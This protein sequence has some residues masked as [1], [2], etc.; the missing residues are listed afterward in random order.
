V[1]YREIIYQKRQRM[2]TDQLLNWCRFMGLQQTLFFHQQLT[3]S[4]L[5]V[6]ALLTHTRGALAFW[7]TLPRC[8][9][10]GR[11]SK[12]EKRI[13]RSKANN[14]SAFLET[15]SG[16]SRHTLCV[17][18]CALTLG[19][20][21]MAQTIITFDVPGAQDT[22]AIAISNTGAITG[23][24]L[25]LDSA[26]HGFLRMPDGRFTSFD[27]PGSTLTFGYSINSR[28]EIT[29]Y[30]Y[31]AG[32]V[33]HGFVRAPGGRFTI[34][35]AP[36]FQGTAGYDINA[37]GEIAGQSV[38]SSGAVHSFVRAVDGTITVYDAPGAG[39]GPGQGTYV[40]TVDGL[41]PD[42]DSSGS[43]LDGSNVWHG[44]FRDRDG[45][46]KEFDVPGAGTATGQGTEVGGLSPRGVSEGI[47]ID[48]SSVLHGFVR[49]ADGTIATYDVAGA[50]TGSGQGT[51]GGNINPAGTIAGSYI[52]SG[53][54]S[55]GY[56]QTA[57]GSVTAFD[58]PGAGTG[59][60][61]GTFPYCNNP[62]NRITGWY[63]DSSGVFHG[64]LRTP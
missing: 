50:G 15:A 23:G 19:V 12:E 11:F 55:H 10:Q 27:P 30:Y 59:A 43:Y 48:A 56:Y 20:C 8:G 22:Q 4:A 46:I 17:A 7:H 44:F 14:T 2:K 9:K 25:G 3:F 39:T 21:A 58:V 42:G 53:N 49:A 28:G 36:G 52:D 40:A 57:T 18:L 29:G 60:G 6:A 32:N 61:Q 5:L 47:F 41:S 16:Y 33:F 37:A 38:D 1:Y 35:D 62:G 64:F 34:F 54:V 13:M 31:D 45:S 51:G 24:Y 26:V 63:I